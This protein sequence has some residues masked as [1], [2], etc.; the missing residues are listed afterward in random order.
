MVNGIKSGREIQG[1][2]G[3]DRPFSY[4]G[5]KI[6]LNIKEGTFSRMM[7]STSLLKGSH[8]ARFIYVRHTICKKTMYLS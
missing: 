7:F 8:K 1:G 5:K 3:C 4:V 2:E 6:V